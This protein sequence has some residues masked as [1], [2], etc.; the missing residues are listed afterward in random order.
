M[1]ACV[2]V[3]VELDLGLK[4][5]LLGSGDGSSSLEALL[6]G[7]PLE[8]RS[9]LELRPT[10]EEPAHN[11]YSSGGMNPATRVRKVSAHERTHAL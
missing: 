2:C 1:S 7:E 8:K 4:K 9:A 6:R 11:E 5:D 3:C 10:D